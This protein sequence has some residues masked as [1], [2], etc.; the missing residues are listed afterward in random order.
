LFSSLAQARSAITAWKEDYNNHRPHSAL[1][2]FSPAEFATKIRL[3]K[4][5]A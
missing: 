3:E 1:G 5:A 4:Q 2:S